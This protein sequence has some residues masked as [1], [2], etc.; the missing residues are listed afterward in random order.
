MAVRFPRLIARYDAAWNESLRMSPL[1]HL[2]AKSRRAG[3]GL[4]ALFVL[5]C[6]LNDSLIFVTQDL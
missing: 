4:I 5:I 3:N 6:L 1:A 2:D